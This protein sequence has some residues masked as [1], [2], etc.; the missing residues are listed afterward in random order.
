MRKRKNQLDDTQ[1]LSLYPLDEPKPE[2]KAKVFF[3]HVSA[4]VKKNLTVLLTIA[5]ILTFFGCIKR[6]IDSLSNTFDDEVTKYIRENYHAS[7][8]FVIDINNVKE[9]SRLEVL[10]ITETKF[11]YDDSEDEEM[12]V[13]FELF[14]AAKEKLVGDPETMYMATGIGTYTIDL[15][16]S[17]FVTDSARQYVYVRV[18]LPE[19]DFELASI[20]LFY[21][22]DGGILNNSESVGEELVSQQQK[23]ASEILKDTIENDQESYNKAVEAA[24]NAISNLIKKYNPEITNLQVEVEFY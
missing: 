14:D 8:T 10:S 24:E 12:N 19:L 1:E 17:E 16:Q 5:V 6:F 7:N 22:D 13:L 15:Q 2:N 21:F 20:N 9:I 23:E 3:F 4:F 18:P 11:I